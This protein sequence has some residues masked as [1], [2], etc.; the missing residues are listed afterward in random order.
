MPTIGQVIDD[1]DSSGG[2]A[3]LSF[4]TAVQC[5]VINDQPVMQLALQ[6]RQAVDGIAA[7]IATQPAGVRQITHAGA[8]LVHRQMPQGVALT[9]HQLLQVHRQVTAEKHTLRAALEQSVGQRQA[10]HEVPGSD[11]LAG[12]DAQSHLH[13]FASPTKLR[14]TGIQADCIAALAPAGV[15][16]V[17]W[18]MLA[19]ATAEA[20]ACCTTSIMCW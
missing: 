5:V 13:G 17:K 2:L 8:S 3:Q 6:R 9:L 15:S 16:S 18:K 1:Q 11:L 10:T 7:L 20:P 19:A 12:I 14:R 4:P